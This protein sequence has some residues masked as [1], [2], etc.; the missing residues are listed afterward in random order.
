MQIAR[1]RA[2]ETGRF[3]IRATN[4][5]ITGIVNPK[6]ELIKQAV[7]FTTA[8]LTGAITPMG[9]LTPYAKIGDMPI[10]IILCV[11]LLGIV[12]YARTGRVS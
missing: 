2:L 8:V 9:G 6:G 3:L 10:L 11:L 12:I 1:M 4:T 7:P 5:G